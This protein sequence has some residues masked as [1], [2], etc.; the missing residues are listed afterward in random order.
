MS[1]ISSAL[2]LAPAPMTPDVSCSQTDAMDTVAAPVQHCAV[3]LTTSGA[4]KRLDW[5]ICWSQN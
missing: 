1:Q 2:P 5:E 4:V 3:A